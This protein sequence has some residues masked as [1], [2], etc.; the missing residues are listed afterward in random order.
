MRDLIVKA[1]E[2]LNNSGRFDSNLKMKEES[3]SK[4]IVVDFDQI[5]STLNWY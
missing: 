2:G 3:S 1:I 5:S 4:N